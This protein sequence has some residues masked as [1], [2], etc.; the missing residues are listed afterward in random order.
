MKR[1]KTNIPIV[2]HHASAL[3]KKNQSPFYAKHDF[4]NHGNLVAKELAISIP[5]SQETKKLPRPELKTRNSRATIKI[6]VYDFFKKQGFSDVHYLGYW[7]ATNANAAGH[8]FVNLSS[9]NYG[10][11]SGWYDGGSNYV[12]LQVLPS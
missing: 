10:E 4:D 12:V 8:Q 6:Q 1:G 3:L 9:G 5:Q 11:V 2:H 7:A